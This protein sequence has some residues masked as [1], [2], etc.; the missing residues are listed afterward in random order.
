MYGALESHSL[1]GKP[2]WEFPSVNS[3][4]CPAAPKSSSFSQLSNTP[5]CSR[6]TELRLPLVRA[7]VCIQLPSTAV[8]TQLV[9]T[10]VTIPVTSGRNPCLISPK[11]L[12]FGQKLD[13]TAP[14]SVCIHVIVVVVVVVVVVLLLLLLLLLLC[15]C[16]YT[17][18]LHIMPLYRGACAVTSNRYPWL[19]GNSS[20][21]VP[22]PDSCPLL[23]NAVSR[24]PFS[25]TQF[26][27]IQVGV[28]F[29]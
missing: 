22:S 24:L 23:T 12:E 29:I 19:S 6:L 5:V 21:I 16:C 7:G 9:Y 10:A 20:M 8:C 1:S 17:M 26:H 3:Y 11:N 28:L 25:A 27:R 4:S 15:C 18:S 13:Q 2:H 14:L